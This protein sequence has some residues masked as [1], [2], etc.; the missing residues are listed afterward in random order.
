MN[1]IGSS[2]RPECDGI[3]KGCTKEI[4][5]FAFIKR[6]D[7]Y[8]SEECLNVQNYGNQQVTSHDLTLTFVLHTDDGKLNQEVIVDAIEDAISKP[9]ALVIEEINRATARLLATDKEVTV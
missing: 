5:S 8:C 4:E 9:D 3:Y 2:Q 7:T 1:N 6:T